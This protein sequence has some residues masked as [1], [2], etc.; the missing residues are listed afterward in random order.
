MLG[1][2]TA[3]FDVSKFYFLGKTND[4]DKEKLQ[5]TIDACVKSIYT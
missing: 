1:W 5:K 4:K 3:R 2:K